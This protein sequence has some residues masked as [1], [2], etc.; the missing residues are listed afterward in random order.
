MQDLVM[1]EKDLDITLFNIQKLI[2]RPISPLIFKTTED[3]Y[4]KKLLEYFCHNMLDL[5]YLT[6][7]K[8]PLVIQ[9]STTDKTNFTAN[10]I[11]PNEEVRHDIKNKLPLLS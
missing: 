8:A 1:R 3:I 2:A 9:V 7:N 10:L 4:S 6:F 11:I 5:C